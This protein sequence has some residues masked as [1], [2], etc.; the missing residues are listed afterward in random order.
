MKKQRT[1]YAKYSV[2]CPLY[3]QRPAMPVEREKAIATI[4]EKRPPL[5]NKGRVT[6][7]AQKTK[8]VGPNG[9]AEFITYEMEVSIPHSNHTQVS[10]EG[11]IWEVTIRHR[12]NPEEAM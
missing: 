1:E 9:R 8:E 7:T 6:P 11:D 2:L 10:S 5:Y 12:K 4:E 3:R